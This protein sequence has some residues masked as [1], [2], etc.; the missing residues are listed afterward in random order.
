MPDLPSAVG[1]RRQNAFPTAQNLS[2]L[3]EH[4]MHR[5]FLLLVTTFGIAT[6]AFMPTLH[7]QTAKE[8]VTLEQVNPTVLANGYRASK[9]IGNSVVNAEK[10]T[11]GKVDDLIITPEGTA[12]FAVLSVGGFLGIGDTLVVVPASAFERSDGALVLPGATKE[13]LKQLPPFTYAN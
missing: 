11:I 5:T 10:E 3:M 1:R 12:P 6:A 2:F 7:A 9:F 4:I 8:T 13:N